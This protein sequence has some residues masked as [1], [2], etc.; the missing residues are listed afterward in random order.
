MSL[1]W[2]KNPL[3]GADNYCKLG[4][5][6]NDSPGYY[7]VYGFTSGI[8]YTTTWITFFQALLEMIAT[9]NIIM[10]EKDMSAERLEYLYNNKELEEIKD[11][12]RNET[13]I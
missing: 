9:I 10:R 5:S 1:Y 2:C 4:F 6:E 13:I 7:I 12:N 8:V 11:F 3:A